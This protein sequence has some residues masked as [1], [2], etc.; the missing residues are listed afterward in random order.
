M[1]EELYKALAELPKEIL[2]YFILMLM[3]D[4]KISFSDIAILH[5]DYLKGL[6]N[7]NTEELIKLRSKIIGLWCGTKK[8]LP[9][10]LVNLIQEGKNNGWVNINQE[11]IDKS[12]WNKPL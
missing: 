1:Y 8:E 12:K 7:L 3:K 9:K 11:E 6:L 5:A 2:E 4:N 10:N